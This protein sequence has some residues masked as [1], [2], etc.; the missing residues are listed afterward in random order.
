MY[1]VDQA[2]L[3]TRVQSVLGDPESTI[4]PQAPWA[5]PRAQVWATVTVLHPLT[6]EYGL[7]SCLWEVTLPSQRSGSYL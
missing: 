5:R 7:L 2:A 4:L 6:K 1:V 3:L